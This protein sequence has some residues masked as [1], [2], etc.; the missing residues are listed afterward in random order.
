[1]QLIEKPEAF[2]FGSRDDA[3]AGDVSMSGERVSEAG[4]DTGD[5]MLVLTLSF[6][7]KITQNVVSLRFL[8]KR[9]IAE[10][11]VTYRNN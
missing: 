2:R 11:L 7:S 8:S 1:M 10:L 3:I 5:V 6:R 9:L 4:E